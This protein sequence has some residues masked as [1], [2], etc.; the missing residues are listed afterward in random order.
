MKKQSLGFAS[1]LFLFAGFVDAEAAA[2]DS[3]LSGIQI[4]KINLVFPQAWN[5]SPGDTAPWTSVRN[6]MRTNK[7]SEIY[8]PAKLEINC[9]ATRAN[10]GCVLMDSVGVRYK[11]NSTFSTSREKN[12]FRISF[13]E[14]GIDQKWN[15]IQGFILNNANLD[16]SHMA[17]KIHM[18]FAVARAGMPGPRFA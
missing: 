16:P 12:P 6:T 8:I 11:G 15:G 9:D 7:E 4:H 1:L 18:D 2:G 13:D 17:E 3:V 14:Y 5:G 10:P